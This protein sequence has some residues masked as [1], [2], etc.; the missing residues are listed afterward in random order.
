MKNDKAADTLPRL[1]LWKRMLVAIGGIC[2]IL[3]ALMWYPPAYESARILLARPISAAV[4]AD[5]DGV[6][7]PADARRQRAASARAVVHGTY[8]KDPYGCVYMV[9][10]VGAKLSLAPLLDDRGQPVCGGR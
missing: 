10:Y 1:P 9:E 5:S 6:I 2:T 4:A 3:L 7:T 8:L